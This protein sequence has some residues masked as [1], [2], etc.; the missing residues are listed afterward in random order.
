MICKERNTSCVI[1]PCKH[2]V[3][4]EE[5]FMLMKKTSIVRCPYCRGTCTGISKIQ[6]V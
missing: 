1:Y 5:C 2:G 4:C 6:D 3:I